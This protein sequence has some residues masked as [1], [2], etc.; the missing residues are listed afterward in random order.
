[1]LRGAGATVIAPAMR[2]S[3]AD[4]PELGADLGGAVAKSIC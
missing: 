2:Q 1:M 3:K 4:E